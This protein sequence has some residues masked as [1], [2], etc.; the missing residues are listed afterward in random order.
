MTQSS[1]DAAR[2]LN[3]IKS[4]EMDVK[5]TLFSKKFTV[6]QLME[7]CTGSML[8]FGVSV[9]S[10][11]ELSVNELVFAKGKTVVAGDRFGVQVETLTG[12]LLQESKAE[13]S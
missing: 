7:L 3:S 5:I 10:S 2:L 12:D 9:N 8:N 4:T 1:E 11:A 13:E 6:G